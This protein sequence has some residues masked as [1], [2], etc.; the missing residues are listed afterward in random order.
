MALLGV[1]GGAAIPLGKRLVMWP[2]VAALWGRGDV[3]T[4]SAL[5]FFIPFAV[6]LGQLLF[7]LGP[8]HE[9]VD[10][11]FNV[12]REDYTTTTVGVSMLIGGWWRNVPPED[13]TY[14]P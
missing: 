8:S 11:K 14:Y 13:E 4:R 5:Q 10:R 12:E 6:E 3:L 1:Q 9:M 7:G 2:R